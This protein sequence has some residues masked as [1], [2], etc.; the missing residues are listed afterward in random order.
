MLSEWLKKA[1]VGSGKRAS[2]PS[3]TAARTKD[4]E[5]RTANSGKPANEVL[6]KASAYLAMAELDRPLKR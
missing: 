3:D 1:E 6:R 2:P 4:V 5:A